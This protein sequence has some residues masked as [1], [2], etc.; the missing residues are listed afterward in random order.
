MK[1]G[2]I[3]SYGHVGVVLDGLAGAGVELVAVAPWGPEDKLPFLSRLERPPAVHDD[4]RRLLDDV[5]PDVVAV[6]T[7]LYR[8]AE[9]SLAAVGAGA[10]VFSEKPLATEA[11]DLARLREA[12][13]AAGVHVGACFTARGEPAF[14]AIRAA[15]A[16]GRIGTPLC[17]TAQKSYPFAARDEF[18]RSRRTYGG[19]IPWQAIHALDYVSWCAG[20]DYRR[21]AA[22]GSNLA[23][24]SHPGME[25]QGGILAELSG[26][27]A[28]TINFDYL[29]PWGR[30]P[31]PW[32]DDRLRIAGSDGV[33]EA[34][35]AASAAELLTPDAAELLPLEPPRNIFADWCVALAGRGPWPVTTAESFRITEVALAAREAQDTQTWVQV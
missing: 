12:A 16:A 9:A 34:R 3:G 18:Y 21:V 22:V 4:W 19:S 6:F 17:A 30:S 20:Q 33:V 13:A 11:D 35:E 8:L 1:L 2:I 28:V 10:H 15:V 23:H 25:D 26:G 14:R 32:G 31:R 24:P 29:R 27:G 5:A 7:P